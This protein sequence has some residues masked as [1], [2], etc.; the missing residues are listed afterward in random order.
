MINIPKGT[1]DILPSESY[2]WQRVREIITKLQNRYNLKEIS[3]PEFENTELFVRGVGDSSDVVNKEMYTFLDKGN[4]S[5]TLKPEGTAGVARS[6]IENGMFNDTLP[7]KMWYLSHCFRYEKPQEGRLRQHTQFGVE[8]YGANTP[9]SNAETLLIATNFYR[10]LGINPTVSINDLGC[11]NCKKAY[12]ETLKEYIR[13]YLNDLCPDCQR[14]FNQNPLRLLDC[15]VSECKEI[16]KNAPLI[17]DYLCDD[18][19][20]EFS[21]LLGILDDLGINYQVDPKLVRGL[22]YYTNLVFEFVDN[23]KKMGQNALGA[24]GR[25]NNLVEQ[26]GGKPTPVIGFGIGIE[27]VLLYL[28]KKGITIEN[29][30]KVDIYIAKATDDNKC[31]LR[32]AES[33]RNNGYCVETDIVGRSLKAQFKYADKLQARYVIVVGDDEIAKNEVMLK[34]MSTGEQKSIAID[35]L[36]EE[37]EK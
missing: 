19:K 35:K 13:P 9:M 16:L 36:L 37:L 8:V 24:G 10:E 12:I 33:L 4:R 17:S 20:S 18:C 26:L 14:R 34:D 7:L 30:N 25:Y 23:D 27:R 2:K 21:T 31:I 5:I 22:D 32:L 3:T 1:K 28:E 15:K 11:E 6:F 29:P